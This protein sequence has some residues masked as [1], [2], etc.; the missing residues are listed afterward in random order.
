[1]NKRGQAFDAFKL[2]I[3]AVVAGAILVILLSM[4]N[5]IVPVGSEPDEVMAQTLQQVKQGGVTKT[6]Q[7]VVQFV[8][9]NGY[10]SDAIA[11]KGGRN[12]G[13]VMF[14]CSG[15]DSEKCEGYM[16]DDI[17]GDNSFF[18]CDEPSGELTVLKD[19]SGKVRAYCETSGESCI[20]GFKKAT[21]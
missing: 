11:E 18:E 10:E 9:G 12:A 4:I 17:D 8:A 6:S 3:A 1:M 5:V 19:I 21:R 20:I 15:V 7:T 14:C 2:L 16:F 13:D